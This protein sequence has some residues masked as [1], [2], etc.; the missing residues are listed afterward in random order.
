MSGVAGIVFR[1][2]ERPIEVS[3]AVAFTPGV[4]DHPRPA[5]LSA[6]GL[7]LQGVGGS[8]RSEKRPDALVVA[9][10]D[11]TNLDDLLTSARSASPGEA[12]SRLYRREG[13]EFLTRLRGP[14]AL[15]IW[16]P[17][18]RR[19]L[20]AGDRFGIR[21]IYYAASGDGLAFGPQAPDV[22]ARADG[23]RDLDPSAIYAYMNFGTVPAPQSM[24]RAVRRLPP[25]QALLWDDGHV[26]VR[27]Y[28]DLAY[29]EQ[30][31]PPAMAAADM[32]RYT[33]EAVR[34]ALVG[35]DPKSTGAFLSGGT[36]SSTV[37]G[38]MARLTGE[39]VHTFSIGF[40]EQRYN[41][42]AYAQLAA[43]HFSA[44][45]YT[46]LVTPDQAFAC[47]PEL[48]AGYDEPFGNNSAIP[49]YLC[50]RLARENGMERLL[51][52]DGGD[53]IFGGN[54]RYRREQILARYGVIPAPIRARLIE[55]VLRALP[56]GG[57]TL[58]G[59]AQRYV[60]RAS[61]P[62]PDRFYSSEFLLA[63]EGGRLLDPG[64][65]GLVDRD[66][67]L[68][69][70]RGHYRAARATSNLN[71]LLYVDMKITLGDNDLLKVSR[72][73]ELAGIAV[74]FPMLD[75]PLV[76]FTATLPARDKVRGTEKRYLFKRAF[77]SLL[78]REILAKTKHGFGLPISDWLKNHAP[79]RDLA[80]DTLLSARSRQRGYYAPGA[81]QWLFDQHQ[82]DGTPYY[83]DILWS[84]LMLE[85]WHCHHEAG[86]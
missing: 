84:L 65:L 47:L 20:L 53:E 69:I 42:L 21:R 43:R 66:G 76:E 31:R 44:A 32:V 63:H 77:A 2:P 36:D 12:L 82:A 4:G 5:P 25:G 59:K 14:F 10:L 64:F 52:G 81:L 17:V 18:E 57:P 56:A 48:V 23:P 8:T 3:A 54:E 16:L 58:L 45:H 1:D 83:G 28:W 37:V 40:R 73:A 68:E 41:E 75:H 67:P 60:A 50:A 27:P 62:N 74:R 15:A 29:E 19:L 46:Q 35:T 9:D 86:E 7:F 51:A 24:Y 70:A 33:E 13:A 78:P 55:P 72:A 61:Q 11:V 34:Q 6:P 38:L 49:T 30:R 80:R 22:L 79:F 71:R 85:L 39:Q 26:S